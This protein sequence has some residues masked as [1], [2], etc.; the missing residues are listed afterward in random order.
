MWEHGTNKSNMDKIRFNKCLRDAGL[1]KEGDKTAL[2]SA[3][4]DKIFFKVLPPAS[5]S[6]NFVR[7]LDGLR[8]V[9]TKL[10]VSLNRIMETIV[11][12]G[13]P[14]VAVQYD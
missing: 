14:V 7:F 1:V 13:Q 3:A 10:R 2:C 12:V 8:H 5:D 6:V 4:V 11:L 9:A